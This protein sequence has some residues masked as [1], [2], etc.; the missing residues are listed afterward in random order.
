MPSVSVFFDITK[1]KVCHM[2]YIFFG[3]PLDK[4]LKKSFI[5]VGYVR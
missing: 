2:I 1:V 3:S 5:I 4:I